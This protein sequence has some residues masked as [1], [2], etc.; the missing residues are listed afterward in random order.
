MT[1]EK[2]C[3]YARVSTDDKGQ[4]VENQFAI[5]EPYMHYRN[6]EYDKYSDEES[7][8]SLN[9]ESFEKMMHEIEQGNYEGLVI[10]TPD[11]YSRT[12]CEAL[13]SIEHVVS[14]GCVVE[15]MNAGITVSR[16]PMPEDTWVF[17]GIHFLM[18]EYYRRH[19]S[20]NIRMAHS[21]ER[22]M[23]EKQGF[24]V[25]KEGKKKD[26]L[27]RLGIAGP[28]D[29]KKILEMKDHGLSLQEIA[30][31]LGSKKST[32]YYVIRRYMER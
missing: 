2:W 15:F 32:I 21:R 29:P 8:K 20:T 12:L 27:G 7:G 4:T 1:N 6:R 31:A 9:R 16:Y 3:I 24:Y 11:R 17:L 28:L 23:I 18:S 19:L 25:T 13:P 30:D 5:L 22:D 10:T 26:H 14:T